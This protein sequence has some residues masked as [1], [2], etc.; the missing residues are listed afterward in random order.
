MDKIWFEVHLWSEMYERA[1]ILSF[2]FWLLISVVAADYFLHFL[3]V[4]DFTVIKSL[5]LTY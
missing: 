2:D 3:F 1:I 4:F 5:L